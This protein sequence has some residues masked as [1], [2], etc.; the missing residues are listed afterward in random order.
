MEKLPKTTI[1]VGQMQQI[2]KKKKLHE[3][4][5][6]YEAGDRWTFCRLESSEPDKLDAINTAYSAI[7]W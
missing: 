6:S 2:T 5:S 7:G 1:E 4:V 3:S